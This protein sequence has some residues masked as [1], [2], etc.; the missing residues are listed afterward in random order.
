MAIGKA[1]DMKIY[2]EFIHSGLVETLV[3]V[4]NAFNGASQGCITLRADAKRG[5]YE[6]ESFFKS[7]SSLVTRRDTTSVAAATDLAVS[8]GE[9]IR[10]KLNRKIGPAANT[11]DSLRKI[12][13]NATTEGALDFALGVQV[14]KAMQ[15]EM[16]DSVLAA[17]VAATAAQTT[18]TIADTVATITTANLVDMLAKLGDQA[19]RVKLWVMHSKVYYDLVKA[20]IAANVDGV[21]NFNIASA[22]PITMNRPVLV[23][24][25]AS[26]LVAGAP[27]KYKTLGLVEGAG[28]VE[29]TEEEIVVREFV[30][31]LEN[32]VVR[33]QGE[34]AYNLGLKG[35]QWDVTNG[36]ANP[37]AAAVGTGT[38]WDKV[39]TSY[40]DLGGVLITTN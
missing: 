15:V 34:F 1:S 35:Y 19:S 6:Y 18:N 25:S 2:N 31:G 5:D 7:I 24:D 40:K 21:S 26:L 20:Q 37:S 13:R 28:L 12:A 22:T 32:L 27:D 10:V 29:N 36:G 39:A 14:A 3:Q 23:S 33:Y 30:T 8:Q 4:S 16:C 17:L 38:N 11:L 9:M